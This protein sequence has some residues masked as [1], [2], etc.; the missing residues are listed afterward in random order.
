MKLRRF[1]V[2]TAL[3]LLAGCGGNETTGP[4]GIVTGSFSFSFAGGISGTYT[5]SGSFPTG[6][7]QLPT[8]QWA[9]GEVSSADGGTWV[10]AAVPVNST[11][12]NYALLFAPRTTAGS[13]TI[14]ANCTSAC[15]FM[16]FLFNANIS[17][18]LP[19]QGCSL[20]SGT[21]AFTTLSS[22]RAVGT[23]SGAG[24]CVATAGGTVTAFTVTGGTFDVPLVTG[25]A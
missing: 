13:S 22:T 6:S 8:T 2:V 24:E 16:E 18:F 4:G 21:I 5:A 20:T 10:A 23:F 25:V 3:G 7:S 14:D 12:Y 15:A 9:A 11:T 1:A 19:V 17:T